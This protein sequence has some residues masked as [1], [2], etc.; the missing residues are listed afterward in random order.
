MTKNQQNMIKYTVIT[1]QLLLLGVFGLSVFTRPSS[2]RVENL[3]ATM[4]YRF[5]VNTSV[6]FYS[7]THEIILSST[8]P[9]VHTESIY[10][11]RTIIIAR[12]RAANMLRQ[13]VHYGL[14]KTKIQDTKISKFFPPHFRLLLLFSC[15][16]PTKKKFSAGDTVVAG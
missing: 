10:H 4:G 16:P 14:K 7:N 9:C 15:N 13:A 11:L 5:P 12:Y 1:E 6:T 3:T 2:P 8:Q